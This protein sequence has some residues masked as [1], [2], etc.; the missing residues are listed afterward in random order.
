M[1]GVPKV[2]GIMK[3]MPNE[4]MC[5]FHGHGKKRDLSAHCPRAEISALAMWIS[6][7]G[8]DITRRM[9]WLRSADEKQQ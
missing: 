5:E 2:A 7:H 3:T 9:R 8:K 1:L 4:D 6:E